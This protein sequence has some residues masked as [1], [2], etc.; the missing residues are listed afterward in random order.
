MMM[1]QDLK[2]ANADLPPSI[3]TIYVV[4]DIIPNSAYSDEQL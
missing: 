3:D 4:H 1:M 2:F